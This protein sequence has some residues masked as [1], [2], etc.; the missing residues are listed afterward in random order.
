M[1]PI[2]LEVV[3][4]AEL[5]AAVTALTLDPATHELVGADE[6]GRLRRWTVDAADQL[7]ETASTP[8]P[9]GLGPVARIVL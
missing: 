7:T 4:R 3:A 2:S 5:P 6:D 1:D 8:L 9:A